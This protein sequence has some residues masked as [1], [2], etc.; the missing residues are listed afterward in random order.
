MRALPGGLARWVGKDRCDATCV[1]SN[2]GAALARSPLPRREGKI[3]SG[4][5][6]LEGID[7]FSPVRSGTL[8]NV[9]LV[10][11]ADKLRI[12]LQSDGRR[13]TALQAEDLLGTYVAKIRAS[14]GAYVHVPCD[15]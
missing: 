11:Y 7:F 12:C 10:F 8:V 13:M 2:L 14:L 5:V 15:A 3:V 9:A 6:V 4:N 1:L